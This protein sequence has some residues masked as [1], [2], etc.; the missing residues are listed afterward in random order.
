MKIEDVF[1]KL[2]PLA[3]HDMDLLWQQYILSDSKERKAIEEALSI[4]LAQNLDETFEEKNILLEPPPKDV[5]AGEY[6]LGFVLYGKDKFYPFGLRENEWIQHIG[7]FGRSGSGKSNIGF[8]IFLNLLK[9]GKR[10]LAFDWKRN[11]RDL[12]PQIPNREILIFTVGRK[13]SPFYFNPLIP[14]EGTPYTTWLNKLIE[15]LS[16]VYYLGHGCAYLLQKAIDSV[17]KEFGV[18]DGNPEVYP[19]LKD[20]KEWLERYKVKGREASWMESTLRAVSVL[21]FGE[22]GEALNHRNNLPLEKLL[23]RNAV[24]ELDS[25]TQSAKSFVIQMLLLWVYHYRMVS[26]TKRESFNHGIII[27]ESHHIL[28]RQ[29]QE[30]QG[31]ETVT[32]IILREI[33]E[34]GE[35]IILLDQHP[36][37]ISKPAMGNTYC[38]IA[39]N[40]KHRSDIAMIADCMLLDTKRARYLGKLQVG[41]GIVKLQ[42]RWFDPFLVRFPLIKVNKGSVTDEMIKEMMSPFYEGVRSDSDERQQTSP[43]GERAKVNRA[44][45]STDKEGK[46]EPNNLA[47]GDAE[48]TQME[49][50]MMKDILKN[51]FSSTTER[52]KRLGFNAY[53]GNKIKAALD[54]K[55][56][57]EVKDVPVRTGRIKMFVLTHR[58][59]DMLNRIGINTNKTWRHGGLEH[60]Y[61][62]NRVAKHF[63]D[64]GY[65]VIEEYPIGKGRAIDL[66]AENE[67]ERI[68]I[69]IETGKSDAIHNMRRAME[70]G[71]GRVICAAL[72][73]KVMKKIANQVIRSDLPPEGE[74]RVITVKGLVNDRD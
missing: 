32:D 24:L 57:I 68:A 71:F 17:Y 10:I 16:S 4:A 3:L 25:L 58:A 37:L 55:G 34:L 45:R 40:L 14:P 61:W 56:L 72:N 50:L 49:V 59:K 38:T 67:K 27:E 2:K 43:P 18:Y 74:T 73:E 13:V 47:A 30:K 35:A 23:E 12:V 63:R 53:Q 39:M 20:V 62:K 28:K 44:S 31:E 1:K 22:V 48:V 54:E 33:R 7:I 9:K 26:R 60:E 8:I 11:F 69:E 6:P 36:S 70:A 29:T 64:I 41:T 66:V 46:K 51:G 65:R 42:D 15:I 21:C 5:A 19:T 52:Y